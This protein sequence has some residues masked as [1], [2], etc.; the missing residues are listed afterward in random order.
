MIDILMFFFVNLVCV[1]IVRFILELVV[2]KIFVGCLFFCG[3]NI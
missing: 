3:D 1:F 2:I